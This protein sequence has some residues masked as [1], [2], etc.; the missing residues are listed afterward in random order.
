MNI[1]AEKLCNF[2]SKIKG[3]GATGPDEI[4]LNFGQTI[5]TSA[6][7]TENTVV[8][9]AEMQPTEFA[10]YESVGL[11]AVDDLGTLLS[12]LSGFKKVDLNKVDN[13]LTLK[14]GGK[15]VE[16]I[17]TN[18]DF[19]KDAP[20]KELVFDESIEVLGKK[21]NTF[22][23]QAKL[24]KDFI[25]KIKTL[26]KQLILETDGKYKF[27]EIIEAKEAVGGIEI[28]VGG[29]FLGM[30]SKF[31][32]TITLK[33]KNNYPIQIIEQT[34]TTK[35]SVIAAPYMDAPKEEAEEP[36]AEEVE[37]NE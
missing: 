16:T 15:K 34:P 12:I 29:P 23:N 30:I 35:I 27:T 22:I 25:L 1:E 33:L 13:L 8:V 32:G 21:I 19:I 36:K 9:N 10:G 24:N 17:L 5:T 7:N 18:P 28:K 11:L 20:Q 6:I 14:E 4:K 31:D 2:L 37:Q 3:N 26:P